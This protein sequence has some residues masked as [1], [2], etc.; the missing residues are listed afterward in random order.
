VLSQ[1]IETDA[2]KRSHLQAKITRIT[3]AGVD[4]VEKFPEQSGL[5]KEVVTMDLKQAQARE[6][7]RRT[8]QSTVI[9][10]PS[11][12]STPAA[13]TLEPDKEQIRKRSRGKS[14]NKEGNKSP[15]QTPAKLAAPEVPKARKTSPRGVAAPKSK[16]RDPD[17]PGPPPTAPPR[18]SM[19]FDVRSKPV[20][21]AV[22]GRGQR[23]SRLAEVSVS[24]PVP[25]SPRSEEDPYEVPSVLLRRGNSYHG[26][27]TETDVP[28]T[29]DVPE[30]TVQVNY[31]VPE[32][33]ES[34]PPPPPAPADDDI[35]LPPPPSWAMDDLTDLPP[36]DCLSPRSPTMEMMDSFCDLPPPPSTPDAIASGKVTP[37]KSHRDASTALYEE[38][39][40]SDTPLLYRALYTY[41]AA[42][43]DDIGIGAGDLLYVLVARDDGWCQGISLDGQVGFFPASYVERETTMQ[44]SIEAPRMLWLYP[45]DTSFGLSIEG[46]KPV[47]V[48]SVLAGT[49]ADKAGVR[50]GDI[51]LEINEA[52]FADKPI[53]TITA[54]LAASFENK[55]KA[56]KLVVMNVDARR[57][58]KVAGI[59][60][61]G[62]ATSIV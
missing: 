12:P 37:Q 9:T 42:Q 1:E 50:K 4:D 35:D 52:P 39:V 30:T 56:T 44:N 5:K 53:E 18:R 14:A 46:T 62:S 34:F 38:L 17:D 60:R 19:M 55:N 51:I 49:P 48:K 15:G 31:D 22:K 8:R 61:G 45:N 11:L 33:D 27:E 43:N 32:I 3:E 20:A 36:P 47:K 2:L 7:E 16:E 25:A 29:Y 26:T 59:S 23:K 24:G 57:L 54:A 28:D 40:E 10:G 6:T 58:E 21:P 41:E 13:A